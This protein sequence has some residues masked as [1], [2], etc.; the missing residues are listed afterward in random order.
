MVLGMLFYDS[1]AAAALIFCISP[2]FEEKYADYLCEKQRKKLLY[3][4]KDALYT[5]SASIAA[6]RQFPRAVDDAAEAAL[7]FAGEKSL[8]WPELAAASGSYKEVNA[9]LE[10]AFEDFAER[11]GTEEIKMFARSCSICKR[12]GGDLEELCLKSAYMLIEK[13]EFGTETDAILAEKKMDTAVLMAMP[14]VMLLFLNMSSYDYVRVLYDTSEGR[15]L[16]SV[17][18]AVM[19]AAVFWSFHIM[20]LKL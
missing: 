15:M 1:F 5:L 18:L 12:T 7:L 19:T 13:L 20:R 2:F 9:G 16:M 17:S 6:G 10:E 3:E 14:P 11:S 8:L 4:F